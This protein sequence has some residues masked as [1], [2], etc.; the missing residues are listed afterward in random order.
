MTHSN[1]VPDALR[2]CC[3]INADGLGGVHPV[4]ISVVLGTLAAD[5]RQT[6]G[7]LKL[8]NLGQGKHG[9]KAS[10]GSGEK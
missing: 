4:T 10:K 9:D 1:G 8:S 5:S 3:H 7:L 6:A 2:V